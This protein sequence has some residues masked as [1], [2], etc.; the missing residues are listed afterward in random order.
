MAQLLLR[1]LDEEL[2]GRLRQ[3]AH[4]HGRSVEEEARVIIAHAVEAST[5]P[6]FGWASRVAAEFKEIGFTDEE[7]ANLEWRRQAMRPAEFE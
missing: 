1:D 4:E 5:A 7:A 6:E 3:R 2:T